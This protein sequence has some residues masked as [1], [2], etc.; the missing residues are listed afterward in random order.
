MRQQ[1]VIGHD[2]GDT[3]ARHFLYF[4][5]N[6]RLVLAGERYCNAS[7]ASPA[8]PANPVDIVLRFVRQVKVDDVTDPLHMQPAASH[9]RSHQHAGLP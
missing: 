9:V 6:E 8:G 1:G 4:R 2:A 7:R 3:L 5:E